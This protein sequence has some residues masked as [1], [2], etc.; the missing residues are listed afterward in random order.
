MRRSLLPQE[1]IIKNIGINKLSKNR[2]NK[3]RSSTVKVKIKKNS[4]NNRLIIN[5]LLFFK[6]QLAKI[7]KGK[8]KVVNTKKN[9]LIPSTPKIKWMLN[10]DSQLLAVTN[11]NCNVFLLKFN[12][13][14]NDNKNN[15]LLI[16]RV[17]IL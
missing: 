17:K 7:V 15:K 3:N 4:I 14:N 13:I 10:S 6:F 5:N 1:I 12:H 9:K 16:I 8:I 2:Q 11:W